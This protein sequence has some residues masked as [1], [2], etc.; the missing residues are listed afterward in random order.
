MQEDH[1]SMG[2]AAARK[3]RRSV[4]GL[5][6]VLAIELLDGRRGIELRAPIEPAA[7]D[8]RG[9][10]RPARGVPGTGPDRHLAPRS[11]PPW[12]SCAR[13][14]PGRGGTVA[15][16]LADPLSGSNRRRPPGLRLRAAAADAAWPRPLRRPDCACRG[17]EQEAALR[18]LE[19]NLHPDVAERPQ[20]LVVY[21]GIGKA[22][23]DQASLRRSS[24][25]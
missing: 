2:W 19:N 13:R 18:M 11:R 24:A 21:G 15:G 6:R 7:G 10:H 22:A 16:P 1:V 4:D 12:P 17:W 3:L 5:T 14:D 20:D 8:G 23:R 9:H 25:S